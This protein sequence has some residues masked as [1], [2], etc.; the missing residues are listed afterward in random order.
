MAP[1]SGYVSR[2]PAARR[3]SGCGQAARRRWRGP[4]YS[5]PR[6][7]PG[8]AARLSAPAAP[9]PSP[10][11]AVRAAGGAQPPT[12]SG[13]G[14]A[15]GGD[16]ARAPQPQSETPTPVPLAGSWLRPGTGGRGWGGA[17][18]SPFRRP[19]S[20]AAAASSVL[21][22]GQ[23]RPCGREKRAEVA[24]QRRG[25][26]CGAPLGPGRSRTA[27][28]PRLGALRRPC[29]G[30]SD[31]GPGACGGLAAAPGGRGRGQVTARARCALRG[32]GSRAAAEARGC[33]PWRGAGLCRA[34]QAASLGTCTRRRRWPR[35]LCS[36]PRSAVSA[37]ASS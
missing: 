9:G 15:G 20:L 3:G 23:L 6:G 5:G 10:K 30:S 16:A 36:C 14:P 34:L 32:G 19:L 25:G 17:A 24:G 33:V 12:A 26:A 28:P 2:L 7:Q 31:G 4:R 21:R 11:A 18:A 35:C 22:P 29:P 13:A 8:P 27:S 1:A 37:S